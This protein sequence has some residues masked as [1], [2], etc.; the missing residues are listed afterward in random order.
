LIE[1]RMQKV[2]EQ[3]KK[4]TV[5]NSEYDSCIVGSRN[6]F[7]LCLSRLKT[8]ASSGRPS[9]FPMV[10]ARYDDLLLCVMICYFQYQ[11]ADGNK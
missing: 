7:P 11:P 4:A 2:T 5:T 8:A 9:L 1:V 10:F 6:V 3:E